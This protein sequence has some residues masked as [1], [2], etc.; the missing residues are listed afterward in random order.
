MRNL[1]ILLVLATFLSCQQKTEN[2][3]DEVATTLED[4]T[5]VTKS[6]KFDMYEMSELALLM[7]QMYVE[8]QRLKNKI[9]A[10]DSLG[11]FPEHFRNIHESAFTDPTEKDAF[12]KEQAA[13]FLA[14]QEK[15][16]QDPDNAKQHFNQAV[17]VCI[18]CHQV[19]CSGPIPKIKKLLIP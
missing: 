16:Y 3:V 12:F 1:S 8:N 17:N 15:I 4:S 2:A 5:T 14:A 7:E 18:E 9:V 11:G 10:N 6:K 19:K 13:L